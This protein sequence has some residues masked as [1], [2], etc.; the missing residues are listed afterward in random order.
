MLFNCDVSF[1]FRRVFLRGEHRAKKNWTLQQKMIDIQRL[2]SRGWRGR[3]GIHNPTVATNF[4]VRARLHLDLAHG[5][6]GVGERGR[7]RRRGQD[8]EHG[9]QLRGPALEQ[10]LVGLQDA[11]ATKQ[12]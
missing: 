8:V 3:D 12:I 10:N 6:H 1:S 11:L 4:A 9:G 2:S 5:E 7:E